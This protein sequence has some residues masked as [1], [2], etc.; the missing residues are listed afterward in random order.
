M[1]RTRGISRSLVVVWC[2]IRGSALDPPLWSWFVGFV[3][4]GSFKLLA[5]ARACR[6]ATT[7]L[8]FPSLPVPP[9][10]RALGSKCASIAHMQGVLPDSFTTHCPV[11]KP[12]AYDRTMQACYGN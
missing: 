6:F 1:S 9:V 5:P 2:L 11:E 7:S 12:G 8:S 4:E 3:G 10:P